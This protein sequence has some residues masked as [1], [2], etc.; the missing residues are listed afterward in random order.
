MSEDIVVQ[1]ENL[2]KIYKLYNSPQDRLKESLHPLRKKYHHDFY[3]LKDIGFEIKKG[4]TVGIVGSN[5]SGKSTLLKIITGIL[6]PTSGTVSVKGHIS[7]LLELG[8]GFNP[9]LSGVENVFFSGTLMGFTKEEMLAKIDDI[10]SFAD[11][12]EFVHQPVKTYSSGMF[13]RLAFAVAVSVNPEIL[14]IDEALSV[15]DM[16]FQRKSF[17]RIESLLNEGMTFLFVSHSLESIKKICSKALFINH[18]TQLGFGGSKQICNDYEQH[19]FGSGKQNDSVASQETPQGDVANID[20]DLL[21]V[22]ELTYG[23]GRA[24]I[25]EV[26]LENQV[27][28]RINLVDVGSDFTLKYR[29]RFVDTVQAPVFAFLIKTVEGI[30]LYGSDTELLKRDSN[31]HLAGTKT[32]ISFRMTN[33]LSEGVYFVNC[34]VKDDKDEGI[35]FMH[36]RVDVLM[37]KSRLREKTGHAGLVNLDATFSAATL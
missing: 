10:L 30:S 7:A 18:G 26:W 21:S 31:T 32:V 28:Q 3:A 22:N 19:L 29:V 16:A 25:E 37:F 15:G 8:A 2:S 17:R 14:I 4:E 1:V 20:P 24:E 34:G 13:V 5:G 23:D 11:I 33:H 27:G 9:E 36:R 6:T 12:G 35:T